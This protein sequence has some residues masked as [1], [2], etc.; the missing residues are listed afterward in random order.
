[1][2]IVGNNYYAHADQKSIHRTEVVAMQQWDAG[3]FDSASHDST[4][5]TAI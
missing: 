3:N 1:M 4:A 5:Y 2:A